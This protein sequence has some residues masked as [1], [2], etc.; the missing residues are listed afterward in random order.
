MMESNPEIEHIVHWSDESI[1]IVNKPPGLLSIPDG[2][3]ADK[4]HLRSTLEPE[5]GRLWI[6]HRLDR[7]TSGLMVLARTR[8]A[9]RALNQQF[10]QGDVF[11]QYLAVVHGEPSWSSIRLDLP[12]LPDG[13]R[14]HRTRPD[15]ARGNMRVPILF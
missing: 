3:D 10:E 2:Y 11:K 13:D 12:L 8:D 1:L 15:L 14:K 9:H 6:V 7:D 4:P 5:F